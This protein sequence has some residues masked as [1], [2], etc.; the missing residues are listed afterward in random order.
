[1]Q[2]KKIILDK[3]QQEAADICHD[4]AFSIKEHTFVNK[5]KKLFQSSNNPAGIYMYGEVGRG[6]TMLMHKFYDELS[7][8]REFV[9]FQKFMQELHIRL[10]HHKIEDLATEIASRVRVLCIDEF[11]VKDITDAMMILRLFRYLL[12]DGVFIF[13]TTNTK[14]DDLYK[15]GLQREAFLPFITMVKRDFQVI[16]LDS[17]KDYRYDALA[18]IRE[19]VLYPFNPSIK[20]KINKIKLALCDE[21]EL[22]LV[23]I[24]LFSRETIFQTAHQNILFTDFMELFE[25][26]LSYA[27]Y[28]EICKH[29]EIIVLESVRA[30]TEDETDIITRF[31]N[32]IDNVY[33]YQ[34]LLF[35]ELETTPEQIYVKGKKRAEFMRT[36]SRLQEMNS[37]GYL[38]R[39]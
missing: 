37:E 24:K 3:R 26:N 5:L 21:E 20:S 14:P 33:F 34:K 2:R 15:D 17:E 16:K 38:E 23:G 11:E 27:D 13:I 29:F 36:I 10:H 1:M 22:G 19:R 18:N 30:I 39:C 4:L 8:R 28:V 35:I 25:R 32:F 9:H 7:V 31:I 6:K 12:K